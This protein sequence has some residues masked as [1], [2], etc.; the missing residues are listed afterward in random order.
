MCSFYD[1][2]KSLLDPSA[3]NGSIGKTIT[4]TSVQ[5]TETTVAFDA[6]A[7]NESALL[8][9]ET[10]LSALSE[11]HTALQKKV[12]EL[13]EIQATVSEAV[14]DALKKE[15]ETLEDAIKKGKKKKESVDDENKRL[16]KLLSD[17]E[18]ANTEVDG[19]QRQ[20]K[21]NIISIIDKNYDQ[22]EAIYSGSGKSLEEIKADIQRFIS[23]FEALDSSVAEYA[24]TRAF[25]ES[26]LGENSTII[27]SMRKYGLESI[28]QLTD[29]INSAKANAEYELKAYDSIIKRVVDKEEAAREAI[30]RKQNKIV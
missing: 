8:A 12:A 15:N 9:K 23:E 10:E 3:L 13:K 24:K 5:I 29:A 6:L 26:W 7:D 16:R 28:P 11:K 18:T 20:I 19:E 14:I 1:D 25:Y 4:A 17:V 22:I 2:E 21:T 27:S 30:E